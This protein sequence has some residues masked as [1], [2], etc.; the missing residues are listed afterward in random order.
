MTL[1]RVMIIVILLFFLSLLFYFFV[2][3]N[4]SDIKV[5]VVEKK[6][7]IVSVYASGYID[8]SDSIVVK[9]EASGYIEKIFVRENEEIKAGQI[10]AIISHSP[11][12]EHLKEVEA[13]IESIREKLKENSDYRRQLLSNI[14]VKRAIL[15]NKERNFYRKKALY[16]EELISKEKF[17]EI[18]REYEVAKQEYEA[19]LSYYKD[20][21]KSL[22]Y[23]I[24]SLQSKYNAIKAEIAKYYI[25]SP[26]NGKVLRKFV[27]EGDYINSLTQNNILFSIGNDKNIETVL[28]VDEEYIPLV[29]EGMKVLVTVDSYPNEIFQ[30]KI[31]V[32]EAQ[33]DRTT[34]TVKVK[35]DVDYH[36]QAF[37][38]LTVEANIIIKE[39]EGIFIPESSYKDGFVEIVER[40]KRRKVKVEI[41]EDKYNGY[42]L[43]KSGLKEGQ[44]IILQ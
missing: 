13:E 16:E 26:I 2:V 35:A 1:K 12:K 40:G 31:K 6:K 27:N 33:S 19:Q 8:S 42:F 29:K 9:S 23:Q 30:G 34:R 39:T 10:L 17:E 20:T 36:K 21:M 41:S 4:K 5:Y 32:V 11:I 22:Q 3:S 15:E 24:Q 44:K 14:D 28:N 43:V 18:K 25:R 7:M 37:F 38:N